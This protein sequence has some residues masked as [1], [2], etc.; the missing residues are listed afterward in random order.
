MKTAD[1]IREAR[2]R[3]GLSQRE[4]GEL[5]G[6][7]GLSAQVQ[8]AIWERGTRQVPRAKLLTVSQVLDIPLEQLIG[9]DK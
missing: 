1:I 2:E 6:Y 7:E 9:G 8:V 3:L 4:L 5:C